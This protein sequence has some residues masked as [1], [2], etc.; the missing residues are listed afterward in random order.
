[1]EFFPKTLAIGNL[2][3]RLAYWV[4]SLQAHPGFESHGQRDAMMQQLTF[5]GGGI[6]LEGAMRLLTDAVGT[7]PSSA[8]ST[9]LEIASGSVLL[10]ERTL[11]EGRLF[12]NN[13]L[14]A[15]T[16]QEDARH[17]RRELQGFL[18]IRNKL[19]H[20]ARI[21]HPLLPVVAERAK[22]RLYDLL[23]DLSGQL[24]T[25]R[26]HNSVGEV[27]RDY[28]DTFEELLSDLGKGAI[29]APDLA[30]RLTLS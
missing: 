28:T 16:L 15:Q 18:V 24:T 9:V 27:L 4:R 22:A 17:I 25:K 26:L 21:D 7:T 11:A 13:A 10:R 12:A 8:A 19:V 5:P 20:R 2:K 3:R 6:S 30:N 1:M 14:L 29:D 23:R